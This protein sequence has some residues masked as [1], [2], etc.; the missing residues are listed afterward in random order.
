MA[1]YPELLVVVKSM[2]FGED[3]L[4]PNYGSIT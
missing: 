3:T 4:V 1:E 2:D